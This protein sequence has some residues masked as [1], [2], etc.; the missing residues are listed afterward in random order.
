MRN[1]LFLLSPPL[2][3]LV[4]FVLFSEHKTRLQGK[5]EPAPTEARVR[6]K[7]QEKFIE[8]FRNSKELLKAWGLFSYGGYLDDG[9]YKISLSA[10]NNIF[11]H[12]SEPVTPGSHK[13]SQDGHMVYKAL[14]IN[15][16]KKLWQD[17]YSKLYDLEKDLV[18]FHITQFDGRVY[19]FLFLSKKEKGS[20]L[21]LKRT[22]F[23]DPYLKKEG[24][25]NHQKLIE[26][27]K[28]FISD[29]K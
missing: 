20:P 9:Q 26:L 16:S 13:N 24:T 17:F 29:I 3:G 2:L 22:F 6:V 12:Y 1:F 8:Y 25:E 5:V 4:L 11:I 21:F 14:E 27:F 18:P 10:A 23:D 19:E 7:E 28:A 15:S